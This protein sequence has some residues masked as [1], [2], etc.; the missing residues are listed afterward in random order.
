MDDSVSDCQPFDLPCGKALVSTVSL[1]GCRTCPE[2]SRRMQTSSIR[3]D[4]KLPGAS[5]LPAPMYKPPAD[6][7]RLDC[8]SLPT[9]TSSMR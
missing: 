4:Q 6:A 7:A 5:V 8:V 3:P 9:S 1:P 2:P